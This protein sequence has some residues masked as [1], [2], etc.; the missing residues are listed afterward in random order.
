MKRWKEYF[1]EMVEEGYR[2]KVEMETN[3]KRYIRDTAGNKYD[4]RI[5][6]D[7]AHYKTR[8]RG[9]LWVDEEMVKFL[10]KD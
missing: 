7:N 10:N 8:H 3:G 1:K 5:G 6:G 2:P 9:R 4:G